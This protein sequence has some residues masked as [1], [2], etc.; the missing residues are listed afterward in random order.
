MKLA[1]EWLTA[2]CAVVSIE[3]GGLHRSLQPHCLWLNEKKVAAVTHVVTPIFGL[4]PETA[5]TLR[6]EDGDGRAES[7]LFTTP[8]EFV[9]LNVRAFGAKGDGSANDTAAIQ[10]AIEACPP[11]S[12]VWIPEGTY[13]VSHLFLKSGLRLEVGKGAVLAGIPNR[14][15]LPIL[16]GAITSTDERAEYLLGTWEGNPLPMFAS[17]LTGIHIENVQIY[18]EGVLDGMANT[19]NW[20]K[21]VKSIRGARRPRMVFLN[22]CADITLAGIT[23]QNSP[24]WHV[25]PWFSQRIRILATQIRSPKNSP[26][27]DGVNPDSCADVEIK[28]VC[29]SVGD[30]C[31]ALKS[32]KRY[33][34]DTYATPCERV[35]IS[36]CEMG[37]GHGAVTLGSEMSGGIRDIL[38][39]D[40]EF[41]DTD[42]G[43][44]IKTRRG[45]GKN[46]VIDSV[47][48]QRIQMRNVKTPFTANCFYFCDPDGHAPEV[49]DRGTRPLEEATPKIR[50][51]VFERIECEGCHAAAAYFLGLP[52]RPIGSVVMRDVNIAFAQDAQ[53]DVPVMAD[54]VAPCARQGIVAVNIE[55]LSLQNVN[56][57]GAEGKTLRMENVSRYEQR[58]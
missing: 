9:T 39:E 19:E 18:G 42:R 48:F 45:R 28:G 40:C 43:L 47:I 23:I 35:R 11:E 33:M 53:A 56:V 58:G 13:R 15:G 12:R 51:L 24:A 5:Y 34:G 36:H 6:A 3:D 50:S 55:F 52:E 27:T 1:L 37:D 4:A 8:H 49:Q 20:W 41:H 16:P 7:L 22:H 38:V 26:N 2:R 29:F 54:G 44:R 46:A 30:D 14:E 17:L 10:A 25:H 57:Y 32:G 21:D 31:V